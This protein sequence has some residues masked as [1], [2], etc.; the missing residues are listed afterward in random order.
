MTGFGLEHIVKVRI[1]PFLNGLEEVIYRP[2]K[3]WISV[4][5]VGNLVI[6]R[7]LRPPHILKFVSNTGCLRMFLREE[8]KSKSKLAV[9]FD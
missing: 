7:A 5:L 1:V 4:L 2:I 3:Q 6:L 8:I 9:T